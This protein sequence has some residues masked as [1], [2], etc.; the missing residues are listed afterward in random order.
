MTG[1]GGG[2]RKSSPR[3]IPLSREW[4][5]GRGFELPSM[6][7]TGLDV[8]VCIHRAGCHLPNACKGSW[9]GKSPY[10]DFSEFDG[11]RDQTPLL[12]RTPI[13][14]RSGTCVLNRAGR[15]GAWQTGVGRFGVTPSKGQTSNLPSLEAEFCKKV[16]TD[17]FIIILYIGR[18]GCA[19]R[20]ASTL[21]YLLLD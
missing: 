20:G 18:E 19:G 4:A 14:E 2:Y 16:S 10:P 3:R 21:P 13:R 5:R 8:S 12:P 11:R 17:I 6:R 15:S 7:A 1:C 9:S